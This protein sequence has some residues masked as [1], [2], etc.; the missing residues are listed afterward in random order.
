MSVNIHIPLLLERIK[1]AETLL[2]DIDNN[3]LHPANNARHPEHSISVQA[4]QAL[5][6]WCQGQRDR[7]EDALRA[8]QRAYH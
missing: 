1:A 6:D 7:H 4:Y 5:A 3:P 8:W 2:A